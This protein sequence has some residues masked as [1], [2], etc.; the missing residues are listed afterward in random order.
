[1]D[2][3][4]DL[5][6]YINIPYCNSK[7]HFCI[8]VAHIKTSD[9]IKQQAVH[10]DYVEALKKQILAHAPVFQQRGYRIRSIYFGGGTP[11]SLSTEQLVDILSTLRSN[12]ELSPNYVDTTLETTP[13]NVVGHDFKKLRAAGFDRISMGV[14]SMIDTRLKGLGRCHNNAQV[15]SALAEFKKGGFDNIN[16]DLM[17]G[18][19]NE[20][21][22]EIVNN[23]EQA[24]SLNTNHCTVYMF[25][26]AE[27]TVFKKKMKKYYSSEELMS[28]YKLATGIIAAHGYNEYQWLYFSKDKSRCICDT[29]YFG[30]TTEWFAFGSTG[31]SLLNRKII[32]GPAHHKDFIE[33]PLKPE[34]VYSPKEVPWYLELH[35][36]LAVSSELGLNADLWQERLGI[37]LED[38]LKAHVNLDAS[39]HYLLEKGW[40]KKDGGRFYF[41]NN[42]EKAQYSC[43]RLA[44]DHDEDGLRAFNNQYGRYQTKNVENMS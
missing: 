23:L 15:V 5:M 26:P 44:M 21:D 12:M 38:T 7:C 34:Q 2:H 40:L 41:P 16:I 29:T 13:E 36:N 6:I 17:I 43:K 20:D 37:S 22:D 18:L 35:Y 4:K 14:Q 27:D 8:Y 33:R 10:A 39:H 32:K 42:E 31:N 9:L 30:L 11:T 24:A 19:P 25:I 28:K 1:M 3:Q